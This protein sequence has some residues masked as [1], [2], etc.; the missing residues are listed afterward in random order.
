MSAVG[1]DLHKR[2]SHVAAVDD[3]GRKLLSRWIDNDPATLLE[4][5][6]GIDGESKIAVEA[7]YGRSGWRSRS[8]RPATNWTWHIPP[9]EGD[10]EAVRASV[11]EAGATGLMVSIGQ[12]VFEVDLED[13]E[14]AGPM[15]GG[16]PFVSTRSM[17]RSISLRGGLGREADA[18]LAGP[19]RVGFRG[20][21]A[22]DDEPRR[23]CRR[24]DVDRRRGRRTSGASR[25]Q[26]SWCA[27][28]V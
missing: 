20:H 11:C 27:I 2:R 23:R 21:P 19:D 3:E 15:V 7:T 9:D 24:G 6:A 25:R 18:A 17:A 1:F 5:L 4:L 26:A 13:G 14:G 12:S 10:R 8:R 22:A 16:P 28:W